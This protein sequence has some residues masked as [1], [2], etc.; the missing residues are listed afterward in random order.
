MRSW[1]RLDHLAPSRRPGADEAARPRSRRD[2]LVA[3]PRPP[4]SGPDR[5]HRQRAAADGND[6]EQPSRVVGQASRA[7]ATV[8]SSETAGRSEAFA[9]RDRWYALAPGRAPR[10][11]TGCRPTRCAIA[12][13]RL[14]GRRVFASRGA[15]APGAA[16][17]RAASGSTVSSRTSASSGQRARRSARNG[18]VVGLFRAMRRRP[19]GSAAPPAGAS[20]RRAAPRCRYRPTGRR[21]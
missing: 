10:S 5:R 17:H 3:P 11:R 8:W 2:E 14:L 9:H 15:R 13:R 18:L 16:R 20:A 7:L 6:L 19:A 1:L 12:V 4:R 21:R